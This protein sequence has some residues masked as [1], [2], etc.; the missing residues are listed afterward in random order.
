MKYLKKTIL[1]FALM[2]I[3]LVSSK[4]LAFASD[5][6]NSEFSTGCNLS[7]GES[8]TVTLFFRN[9]DVASH[10]YNLTAGGAAN[11]YEMYFSSNGTAIKE[12]MVPAGTSAQAD[13]NLMLKENVSVNEDR[14]TVKATRD[15]GKGHTINFTVL[16]NKD[17]ALSVSSMPD[18]INVLNG[19]SA[20]LAFSVTNN[21]SK[22]I[23]S[24]KIKEEL[25]YKWF[26]SQG[27]DTSISLKPG[28]TGTIK[29]TID[30]PSSQAAGNFTAKFTA[31]SD[32]T[33][34]SQ[35]SIP[36]TVKTGL[37]IAYWMAGVLVLIAGFTLIQFKRHG[38][39]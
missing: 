15:D 24:V 26:P 7:P 36:V 8:K 23:N 5:L 32:K 34:S 30:V 22:D 37:N 6:G 29:M 35:I 2:T 12:I 20:E 13:L 16:V 11:S 21:G 38:R 31:V 18:K 10:R 28:E 39:R 33:E 19:K 14:L 1:L 27:A 17:Y 9:D 4:S 25:P 3:M